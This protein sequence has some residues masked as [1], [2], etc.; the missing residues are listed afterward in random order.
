LTSNRSES[1]AW[2]ALRQH[3]QVDLQGFV[4]S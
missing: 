1:P 4:E 2:L 3:Y